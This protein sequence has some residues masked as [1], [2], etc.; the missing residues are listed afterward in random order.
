[1]TPEAV[2]STCEFYRGPWEFLRG[3]GVFPSWMGD[4][5]IGWGIP[6]LDGKIPVG[7]GDGNPMQIH[8]KFMEILRQSNGNLCKSDGIL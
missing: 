8:C 6:Q 7:C 4:S 3:G 1:M 5:P 2:D